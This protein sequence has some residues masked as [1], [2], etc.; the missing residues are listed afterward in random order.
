MVLLWLNFRSVG[1]RPLPSYPKLH[2][3]TH[4]R[5]CGPSAAQLEGQPYRIVLYEIAV[6]GSGVLASLAR[7]SAL[8]WRMIRSVSAGS[9]KMGSPSK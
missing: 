5:R 1:L 3:R 8:P 4:D 6:G 2:A 7:T 9:F